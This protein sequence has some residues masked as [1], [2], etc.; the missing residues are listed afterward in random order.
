MVGWF[1]FFGEGLHGDPIGSGPYAHGADGA[2]QFECD[3]KR[4]VKSYKIV[5]VGF[6]T[7][8]LDHTLLHYNNAQ[9]I[10]SITSLHN[11]DDNSYVRICFNTQICARRSM[12]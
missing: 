2:R 1:S 3:V 9:S 10:D 6:T 12:T 7:N 11:T 5:H 4:N 8:A